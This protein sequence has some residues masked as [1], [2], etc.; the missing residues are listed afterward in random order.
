MKAYAV[1]LDQQCSDH[2]CAKRATHE[3]RNGRNEP[4]RRCCQRHAAALVARL[5]D[6]E[7]HR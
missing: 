5:N 2:A 3:V 7:R 6:E 4:I 1:A